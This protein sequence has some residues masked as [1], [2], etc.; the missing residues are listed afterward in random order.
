MALD[1][2]S[3]RDIRKCNI[4]VFKDWGECEFVIT[5]APLTPSPDPDHKSLYAYF[6]ASEK[7]AK[8]MWQQKYGRPMP[9]RV[10]GAWADTVFASAIPYEGPVQ[11][12]AG[13]IELIERSGRYGDI[14]LDMLWLIV[15]GLGWRPGKPVPENDPGWLAIQAEEELCGGYLHL[16]RKFL[17]MP[18]CPNCER[19]QGIGQDGSAYA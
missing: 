5:T 9:A 4:R 17:G 14:T 16:V 12:S 1:L 6:K 15:D 19:Q 2:P 13:E 11:L 10:E 8:E 7:M 18:D 3:E